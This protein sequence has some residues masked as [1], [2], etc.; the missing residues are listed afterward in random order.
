MQRALLHRPLGQWPEELA[1]GAL[2]LDFE[3]RHRRRSRLNMDLGEEIL[4][5]LPRAVAMHHGD[6]LQ[7]E[8]GRW[9]RVRAAAEDVVE[10]SHKEAMQLVRI[11]WHLG[12]RHTPTQIC[13]RRLRIRADRV[14]EAMLAG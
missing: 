2:T 14:I 13:H 3:A 11:A 9:L 4:L 6:G 5:E 1:A 8:D 10:V 12:N 7:L